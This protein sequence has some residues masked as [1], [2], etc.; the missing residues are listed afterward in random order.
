M[1]GLEM[2]KLAEKL[3]PIP[4]SLTGSGVRQT[5]EILSQCSNRFQ[6]ITFDSGTTV[7]DWKIPKEWVV[8]EAY[9]LDPDG[10]RILD[11]RENNLCL[12]GYSVP[13][14]GTLNLQ[15]FL[16]HVHTLEDQPAATPYVTSY[17][18]P[19]WGFCMPYEKLLNLKQGN[20]EIVVD[21][22][23][24]DGQLDMAEVVIPGESKTEVFFSTYV[25]HPSMAN[26][27]VS[28]PVLAFFLIK[29]L[30]SRDNFYTYRFVLGP[31]TI[32]SIAYLSRNE[33]HLRETVVA[34]F[35][36]TCVGDDRTFSFLPSRRGDTVSDRVSKK[37]L[38]AS[39]NNFQEYTW[40]DRG[41]D[42]RQYCSPGVDLP[43]ASVMRSKY[44]EYPE[45]HTDLDKLGTV[46]T[47]E[48]LNGSL[49]IYSEIIEEL[50]SSRFPKLTT[51]GEPFMTKYGKYNTLSIKNGA[52][53]S[54][55]L[56]FLSLADGQSSLEDI[57]IRIGS[58][59]DE[60]EALFWEAQEL[61]LLHA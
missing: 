50:E 10:K 22:E 12:V 48:G 37:V 27:E 44:G 43:M 40:L 47:A 60:V 36:L 17:Y 52:N 5:L 1:H 49:K 18:S 51:L 46:V 19:R 24:F 42:E 29:L 41:S 61:G 26:N 45:Y 56:D 20:Y 6:P 39:G 11:F 53:H 33:S 14:R 4:R 28:G 32:G 34:G 55:L 35:N 8:R 38:K 21:T 2:M 13:F 9:V 23:L 31:E 25:C 54:K 7:G 3:F 30:E 16:E 57:A 58:D 59:E 15:E